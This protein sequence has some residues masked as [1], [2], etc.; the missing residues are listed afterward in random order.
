MKRFDMNYVL[1]EHMYN[2]SY[3]PNFLVDKIKGHILLVIKF[4]EERNHTKKEIQDKFDKMTIAINDLAEEFYE[5]NSE[6]ETVARESIGTT[7]DY[8]LKWFEIDIDTEEAI[9][10]RDW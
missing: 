2:D 8:I 4:I 6:L 10:E 1:L 7:V 9:R 5:N 3:F